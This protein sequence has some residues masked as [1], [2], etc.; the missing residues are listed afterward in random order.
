MDKDRSKFPGYRVMRAKL[1]WEYVAKRCLARH[2][3]LQSLQALALAVTE[4]FPPPQSH[5]PSPPAHPC[6]GY[7]AVFDAC[8]PKP[9]LHAKRRASSS[10][11]RPFRNVLHKHLLTIAG[12]ACS[13]CGSG[14]QHAVPH[15]Q[16]KHPQSAP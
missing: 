14:L 13:L 16:P 1:T 5:A 7:I 11:P 9:H 3:A 8:T 12:H 6:S 4:L 10:S 2:K 15:Q